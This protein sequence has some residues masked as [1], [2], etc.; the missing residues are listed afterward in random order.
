MRNEIKF[1]LLLGTLCGL[2]GYALYITCDA[3]LALADDPLPVIKVDM[4]KETTEETIKRVAKE[5]GLNPTL[6]LMIA[7]MESGLDPY[8]ISQNKKS[9]DRGVFAF[10]SRAYKSV[11]NECAFNPECA[12]KKFAEEV[13]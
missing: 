7:D 5:Q 10:N 2:L 13:K 8:F 1:L 11:S 4:K 6:T 9:I 12:T 3:F